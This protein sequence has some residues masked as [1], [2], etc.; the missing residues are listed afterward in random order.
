MNLNEILDSIK[1]ES[2]KEVKTEFK[3]LFKDALKDNVDFIKQTA[4]QIEQALSYRRQGL[5]GEDDVAT[6][7]KK[8]KKIA[9]IQANTS[10]IVVKTRIQKLVY[11]L[12]DIAI[13][14]LLKAIVP[15]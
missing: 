7:L 1:D 15:I 11:R 2:L 13:D 5:I 4:A 10:E 14:V 6:L 9:Q 8:Q 3:K 12:L